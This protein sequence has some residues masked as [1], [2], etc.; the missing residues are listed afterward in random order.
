MSLE[1]VRKR[2][3]A[4]AASPWHLRYLR[5]HSVPSLSI[6]QT[7]D[8]LAIADV[9]CPLPW[10]D[11]SD[12]PQERRGRE[13]EQTANATANLI[14]HAPTDLEL[15][16]NVVEAAIER[17]AAQFERNDTPIEFPDDMPYGDDRTRAYWD[18]VDR[19]SAR[20]DAAEAAYTAALDAFEAAP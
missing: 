9:W 15:M 3:E 13:K 10:R 18:E 14:A 20:V 2:L 17:D 5:L 6:M 4:S 7:D 11:G 12:S 1:S 16:A 19:R 8:D